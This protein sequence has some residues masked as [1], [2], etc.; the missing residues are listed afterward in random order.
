MLIGIRCGG[1]SSELVRAQVDA[2]TR[3]NAR[4]YSK[5]RDRPRID[6]MRSVS[7]RP[8][9]IGEEIVIQTVDTWRVVEQVSCG[10]AAA[11]Y[12]GFERSR[13]RPWHV[14]VELVAP[15]LWHATCV[16][17]DLTTRRLRDGAQVWDPAKELRRL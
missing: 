8:D 2:A 7:Y 14:R 15:G 10:T 11:A 5:E 4:L 12:A 3:Y 9:A 16:L 1:V 17:Y 6:D 13:G